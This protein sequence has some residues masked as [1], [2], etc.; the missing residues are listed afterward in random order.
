MFEGKMISKRT[1]TTTDVTIN[2]SRDILSASLFLVIGRC[3]LHLVV[4]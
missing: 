1:N 4:V 2:E 3:L